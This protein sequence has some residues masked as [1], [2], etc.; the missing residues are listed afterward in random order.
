MGLT[1]RT[2]G[3]KPVSGT[4]KGFEDLFSSWLGAG[5]GGLSPEER[6][7]GIGRN[8]G[9]MAEG[10]LNP[11]AREGMREIMQKNIDR[12]G[13]NIS[14]RYSGLGLAGGGTPSGVAEAKFRAEAAPQVAVAEQQ[15]INQALAALAPIFGG[16]MQWGSLGMPQAQV[17]MQPDIWQNIASSLGN[18]AA[19]AG[20]V[21]TGI[22][23]LQ[24]AGKMG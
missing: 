2:I 7:T 15:M 12:E 17:V 1:E 4:A 9:M 19:S 20:P 18:L 5:K 13:Q 16:M 11:G 6:T 22:G 23:N 14:T 10:Y 3:G 8:I 24:S 21:M